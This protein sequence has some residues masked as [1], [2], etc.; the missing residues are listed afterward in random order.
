MITERFLVA[1]RHEEPYEPA[2]REMLLSGPPDRF[3]VEDITGL[4]WIEID[5]PEDLRR[6]REK[7]LPAL[8]E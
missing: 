3:G 1:D 2:V 6:A 4:P 7:I 8:G 5:T